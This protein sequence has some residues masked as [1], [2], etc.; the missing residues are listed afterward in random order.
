V[1]GNILKNG[2]RVSFSLHNVKIFNTNKFRAVEVIAVVGYRAV[3]A[4]GADPVIL[5]NACMPFLP[6]GTSTRV[7]DWEFVVIEQEG[8]PLVIPIPAIQ[9]E[10]IQLSTPTKLVVEINNVEPEDV[11]KILFSIE[12][13][14][15]SELNSYTR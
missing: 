14:G 13:L 12:T 5:F 2:N 10:S 15:Y 7:E 4:F 11:E 9:S 3:S 1:A 8:G 6:V